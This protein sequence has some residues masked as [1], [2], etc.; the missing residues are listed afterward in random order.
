MLSSFTRRPLAGAFIACALAVVGLIGAGAA[1]ASA[2]PNLSVAVSKTAATVT[3]PLE[4]GGVNVVTTDS[5]VK[6]ATVILFLLKPGVTVAAAESFVKSKKVAHDPNNSS[7]LGSIQ[8]DTE[9]N[10][11]KTSEAQT[12]LQPGQYLVLVGA[13]EGEVQIRSNFTV[14]AAKSPAKLTAPEATIRSIEFGFRGPKT[15]HDG[16]LVR[17]ENEGFLVHMNIAFPVKNMK[18]AEQAVNDLKSGKEKG[19]EKLVNGPPVTFAGPIS[20]EAFQQEIVSAKP[21]IYVEVCFM[22]TQDGRPHTVL[23]MERIIKIVK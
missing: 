3:G 23:G 11:G 9:A 5:G 8:F 7:K 20:H 22:T 15:I 14:A 10:P 18:A 19:V 13:G 16:Q 17:F 1:Q 2:P 21:G 6:E 4:S 12:E